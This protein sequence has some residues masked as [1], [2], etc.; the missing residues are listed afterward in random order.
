MDLEVFKNF[1]T[2][3]E[4]EGIKN[5]IDKAIKSRKTLPVKPEDVLRAEYPLYNFH[6]F[7]N[8]RLCVYDIDYS[9][10]SDKILNIIKKKYPEA[11]LVSSRYI[12]YSKR[13]GDTPH[14]PLHKDGGEDFAGTREVMFDYQLDSNTYWDLIVED[15]LV[16]LENNDA[17]IFNPYLI[18]HGRPPKDFND[19]EYKKNILFFYTY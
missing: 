3:I 2:E 12:E 7:G 14:L 18:E 8:S 19:E 13:W 5:L 11:K 16:S 9:P 4:V 15:Q 17:C 1:F 6:Y 10:Y